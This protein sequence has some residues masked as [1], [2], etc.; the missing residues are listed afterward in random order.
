MWRGMIFIIYTMIFRVQNVWYIY[1]FLCNVPA[2]KLYILIHSISNKN[3][4]ASRI[5]FHI[6]TTQV[7]ASCDR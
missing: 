3:E 1:V 5:Q 2:S 4:I 6:L 7:T